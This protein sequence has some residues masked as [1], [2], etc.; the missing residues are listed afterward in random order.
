M[1]TP[2]PL[3]FCR[4]HPGAAAAAPSGRRVAWVAALAL[5]LTPWLSAC[6]TLDVP[7]AQAYPASDQQKARAVHHWDLLAHDVASRI[8]TGPTAAALPAGQA[9]HLEAVSTSPF[10]QA[11]SALLLTRLVNQGLSLST[12]PADGE[13][14]HAVIRFDVQ[15]VQHGSGVFNSSQAPATLLA[16]GLSVVRNWELHP[17]TGAGA[18]AAGLAVGAL[19]DVSRTALSGTA[20]GGPTRT[21]VLVS[22]TVLHGHRIVTRTSDVYYIDADDTALFLPPPPPPP[23]PPAAPVKQWRV[24][25]S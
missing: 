19:A 10:H 21:E 13:R 11:F 16:A 6:S 1:T 12:Q 14:A 9:Y 23:P 25:G 24:I 4:L 5:L 18:L 15:V 20:A 2:Q 7:R 17:P 8:A 22:S 3:V